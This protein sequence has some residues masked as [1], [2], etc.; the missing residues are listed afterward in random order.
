MNK[1]MDLTVAVLAG[2]QE[3]AQ[4]L[5]AVYEQHPSAKDLIAKK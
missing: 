1:C 4:R 3:E 5:A 2:N